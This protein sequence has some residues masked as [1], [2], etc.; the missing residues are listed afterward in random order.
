MH[1]K[2]PIGMRISRRRAERSEAKPVGWMRV[3]A[4]APFSRQVPFLCTFLKARGYTRLLNL[5]ASADT[6]ACCQRSPFTT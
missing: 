2:P 6:L 1:F 4:S 5:A 3:L